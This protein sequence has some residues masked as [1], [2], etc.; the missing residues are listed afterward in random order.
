MRPTLDDILNHV[1]QETGVFTTAIRSNNRDMAVVRAR[2][3]FCHEAH[4]T[5][6]SYPEITEYLGRTSHSVVIAAAKRGSPLNG[7]VESR[8]KATMILTDVDGNLVEIHNEQIVA[9]VRQLLECLNS[10]HER[11][12]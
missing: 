10:Q 3:S 12:A 2:D 6:Y 9:I 8:G 5:G 1:S 4:K 7:K 11:T